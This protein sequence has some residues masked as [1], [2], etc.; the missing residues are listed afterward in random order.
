M[1]LQTI[2]T[3]F[4]NNAETIRHFVTAVD[5]VQARWQPDA[6]S[7]SILEVINHLYDEER[8]DFRMRLDLTLHQPETDWPPID[9]PAWAIERRYNERDLAESLQR[10]LDERQKSIAW[11]NAL[12]APAW[13]NEHMAPWGIMRAGD[14]MISWL[15]H[16]T[17]HIRQL[18][19]LHYQYLAVFAPGYSGAYAGEW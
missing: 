13:D 17:L 12:S 19:E 16:D 5:D 11:L 18:A 9:P 14:V 10:F 4:A 2:T 1:N 8:E 3:R 6:G 15:A 7:W